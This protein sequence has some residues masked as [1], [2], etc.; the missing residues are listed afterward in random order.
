MLKM[1]PF[2]SFIFTF[3][4]FTNIPVQ[5]LFNPENIRIIKSYINTVSIQCPLTAQ[6]N[7]ELLGFDQIKWLNEKDDFGKL[8]ENV[9]ITAVNLI[10]SSRVN[11]QLSDALTYVSCGYLSNNKYVRLK[12]WK[13]NYIGKSL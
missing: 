11:I 8:D 12:S 6:T 5:S 7:N 3:F 9:Q 2:I 13:L 1:R 10:A 4:F